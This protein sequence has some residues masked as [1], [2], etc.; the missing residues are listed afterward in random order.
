MQIGAACVYMYVCAR[1]CIV[2]MHVHSP[3]GYSGWERQREGGGG[4]AVTDGK[5]YMYSK[6][7]NKQ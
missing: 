4:G 7:V 2:C 3:V 6:S 1:A 5:V